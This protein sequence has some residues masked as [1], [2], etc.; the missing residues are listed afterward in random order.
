MSIL[1]Q[2]R[3][4]IDDFKR[5]ALATGEMNPPINVD[6]NRDATVARIEIP[7]VGNGIDAAA[8]AALE[9][10]R[11]EVLPAT[12]GKSRGRRVRRDR[13][14]RK[15][16]G[17]QP[18]QTSSVPKVFGFVLLFAFGLL[19]VSFRSIVIASRRSSSTCSRSPPPTAS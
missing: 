8:T 16:A 15:L 6:I 12:V 10:L 14:D 1:Q 13:S 3:A 18:A 2:V 9:T 11:E 4:A 5:K 17:L 19:L 7:L